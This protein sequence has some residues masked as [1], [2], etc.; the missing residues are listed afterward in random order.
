[1]NLRKAYTDFS[2]SD[3]VQHDLRRLKTVCDPEAWPQFIALV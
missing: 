1:M 2:P 3:S